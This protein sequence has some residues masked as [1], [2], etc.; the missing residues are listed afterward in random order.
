MAVHGFAYLGVLLTF[1]GV[2][3]FL[4]F[5][6]V[7]VPDANQPFVELFIALVFFG[8]AWVLR[9][10]GADRVASGMEL[11]GGMVLPL[12][13]FAGFVDNAPFPPDFQDGALVVALTV[14]AVVLAFVYVW[15]SNRNPKSTLRFLVAP[16]LWL[17]AMTLGFIFKTD[18]VLTSDAITR[19]VSAQPA[20][21]SAAVALTLAACHWRPRHRL[22]GPSVTSA[23]IGLPVAYLLTV[24]LSVGEGWTH[25]IPIV[26]LGVSTLVSAE[27][28]AA[29]FDRQ[30]LIASLRPLLV[31]GVVAPLAPIWG[32]GWVGLA[33]TVLYVAL[34]EWNV[35]S[36]PPNTV[37]L[38]LSGVGVATGLAMSIGEPW[39]ALGAFTVGSVWAQLRRIDPDTHDDARPGFLVAAALLPIGVGF[40]L[41]QVTSPTVAWLTMSA[42]LLVITVAVRW[43]RTDDVFWA[44]WPT[45][46]LW[47]VAAGAFWTWR[48]GGGDAVPIVTTVGLAALAVGIGPRWP[49]LRL[50]MGATLGS[51]GLAIA[52][53]A[54]AYALTERALVWALTG[55][56]LVILAMLWRRRP[57]GHLAVIGHIMGLGALLVLPSDTAGAIVLGAW[58]VGWIASVTS[59]ELGGASFTALLERLGTSDD[60]PPGDRRARAVRW[61]AP[62]LMVASVPPAVLS[63]VDLWDEFATHRSWTGVTLAVIGVLYAVAARLGRDR[64]PLSQVLALGAIVTSIIGVAVAAPDSWPMI[65]AAG[66]VIAISAILSGDLRRPG[67]VWFAWIMSVVMMLLLGE[68]AGVST[69]RL[70]L[71]SLVW[72]G[73]M[74]LGGLILDDVRSGRRGR[75]EG[76]RSRW[77]RHPVLLGALVV[78]LSLGPTFAME[79]E[80]Y[81]W[82]SLGAAALYFTVA[83][84]LRGGSVTAPAYGLLTLGIAAVSPWSLIDDPWR[85]IVIAAP[86]VAASWVAERFQRDEVSSDAWLR[87]DL[88][89]LIVAH[90]IAAVAFVF[91]IGNEA[92]APSALAFGILSVAIGLWRRQRAWIEV[93]NLMIIVAAAATGFDWLA[94]A[95]SATAVRG[96]VST[97]FSREGSRA[98]YQ[99][100]GV[101]SAG[102]TWLAFVRWQDLTSIDAANYS[103]ILF[104]ALALVVTVLSRFWRLKRDT[105]QYWGG[106][107]LVGTFVAGTVALGVGES[108]ING[109]WLAIGLV[110]LALAFELAA[111]SLGHPLKVLSVVATGLAWVALVTGLD[112][113]RTDIV[114]YSAV[115]FGGLGLVIA[116][117]ARFD[118][119]KRSDAQRW[120]ALA[121]VGVTLSAIASLDTTTT[122]INGAWLAIGLVLL[123][124]AFELAAR[125]LQPGLRYLTVIAVGGAWAALVT[126][127]GWDSNTVTTWTMIGFGLL[128]LATLEAGR[129]TS[130]NQ[131][132]EGDI[133]EGNISPVNLT[134]A[135]AGL[136]ALG[137]V[138]SIASLINVNR[139]DSPSFWIAGGFGVLAIGTARGA[140]PLSLSWLR[141]TSTLVGLAAITSLA[142][143]IELDD[144]GVTLTVLAVAVLA[145]SASLWLWRKNPDSVWMTP[146]IVLG[147]FANLEAA[148]FALNSPDAADLLVAVLFS[149]GIQA[150]AIGLTLDRAG[151]LAIGPPVIGIAFI[152]MIGESVSGSAQWY[153]VPIGLVLLSEV[154]ILRKVRKA[155]GGDMNGA[156]VMVLEWAGIALLSAPPL[157]EMFTSA[158]I[159]GL[160]AFGIAGLL[161]A[162]AILTMVRRRAITAAAL[163]VGTAVLILF[164]AAAG[165]A[166][167]SAFF[168]IV[169]VGVGFAV[170]LVAALVEAYRSKKGHIMARVDQL[171]EGWS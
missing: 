48:V 148:G 79:P 112:W 134:R 131:A 110:L 86:M 36:D 25:T 62:L 162:W 140:E 122:Y 91:A 154:E 39:A 58:A 17:A 125:D 161:L 7:D 23:L 88:A 76:L 149:I 10:Q 83:V 141:T 49:A 3:G 124:L 68:R 108:G 21:A 59:A 90:L 4:L 63:A 116:L 45:A 41:H 81:G 120:V 47:I 51:L 65:I 93:G 1:V 85:F 37:A 6:F 52:L 168:W 157:V 117:L 167:D 18:E 15:I 150:I 164:A 32:L 29:W 156:E 159:Y 138:S 60:S 130:I 118:I 87:W 105:L 53:D 102:M 30:R 34:F 143:A 56:S 111:D 2:L 163:A 19:L 40:A 71:V 126:G 169:A 114:S 5:A 61:T 64:K 44:Y 107:A 82:W 160:V 129:F 165:G 26:V 16:L 14:S 54:Q 127:L 96:S 43:R 74:M 132:T 27:Y 171:M 38:T 70:A 46:S 66:S 24:A 57:A 80:T 142:F 11:I 20:M 153:T 147:V 33:V 73:V 92:V 128:F 121:T 123:A 106:L 139:L 146:L 99:L 145:T 115:A 103:V 137:V 97:L 13:L 31:A 101:V 170:S 67:F 95:L 55:L 135:W 166:P 8:W 158:I 98:S 113:E 152:L 22:A 9:R 69:D 119:M 136:G 89:P 78:P 28:L 155:S 104:P 84:I 42:I 109:A 75:G 77:L 50:W 100:I 94:L 144:V 35:R 72:G 133:E 151:V 12:I